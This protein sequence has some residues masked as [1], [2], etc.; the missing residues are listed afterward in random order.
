MSGTSFKD[1]DSAARMTEAIK[2]IATDAVLAAHPRPR[3]G[4]A[5]ERPRWRW[6]D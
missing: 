2:K 4:A 1:L 6:Q 3:G 5:K